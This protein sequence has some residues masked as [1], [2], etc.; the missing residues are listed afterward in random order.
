[1]K[2]IAHRGL[3]QGPNTELENHPDQ[4]VDAIN[5][6]FDCEIDL[7]VINSELVLGHDKPQYNITETFLIE[8]YNSL[9]VH[10]K[11]LSALRW[12]VDQSE[13]NFF[14]HQND[15]YVITS[16]GFI[17]AYPGKE[18]TS[19]SIMLMPEW[20]NPKL[21]NFVIPN[22]YGICSDY[23]EKIKSTPTFR[24]PQI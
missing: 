16:K 15:D 18:L 3:Y 1:M 22:C 13:L 10:A 20:D 21:K 14:W 17:W 9:W 24:N 12:L 4:I 7:W 5:Q 6:G 23:V 8:Y 2:L 19:R 11:N